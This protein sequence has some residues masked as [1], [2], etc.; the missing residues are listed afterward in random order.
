MPNFSEIVD[1][2]S[3]AY[4]LIAPHRVLS[5]DYC[6]DPAL[7]HKW[8]LLLPKA[9]IPYQEMVKQFGQ[10]VHQY[11][12]GHQ[13]DVTIRYYFQV[14]SVDGLLYTISYPTKLDPQTRELLRSD[15]YESCP[16][17]SKNVQIRPIR[18]QALQDA[19]SAGYPECYQ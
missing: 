13:P 10:P 9:E 18:S 19:D 3:F 4:S 12:V 6:L 7:Y 2:L 17:K 11:F 1:S 8:H 5:V 14:P 15:S 16:Q